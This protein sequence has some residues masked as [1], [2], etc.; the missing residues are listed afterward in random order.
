M[1]RPISTNLLFYENRD[2]LET[3]NLLY[4]SGPQKIRHKM[5][6]DI[7]VPGADQCPE[8]EISVLLYGIYHYV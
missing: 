1:H 5:P 4:L 6:L 7:H 3:F 8:S 2:V